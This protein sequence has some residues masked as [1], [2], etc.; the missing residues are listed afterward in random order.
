MRR[1]IAKWLIILICSV[2]SQACKGGNDYS[3]QD[4]VL[5][6]S[7]EYELTLTY[8][9]K[10]EKQLRPRFLVLYSEKDPGL[11]Q[12]RRLQNEFRCAPRWVNYEDDEMSINEYYR[13]PRLVEHTGLETTPEINDEGEKVW[14]FRK[15]GA[16]VKEYKGYFAQGT[17]NPFQPGEQIELE[18]SGYEKIRGGVQYTFDSDSRIKIICSITLPKGDNGPEISYTVKNYIEGYYSVIFTGT[19]RENTEEV[20]RVPSKLRAHNI[21]M[22]EEQSIFPG[23][24][25]QLPDHVSSLIVDKADYPFMPPAATYPM[26]QPGIEDN[27][28][29]AFYI[30]DT[31]EEVQHLTFTPLMGAPSSFWKAGNEYS[32]TLHYLIGQNA[33]DLFQKIAVG[34]YNLRD[35]RDNSGS[36][37]MGSLFNNLRDYL[38]NS[39]GTNF[40]MW[41]EEQKYHDYVSDY[42]GVFKPFS[43]LWAYQTALILDDETLYRERALPIIE[44]SLT[45]PYNVFAPYTVRGDSRMLSYMQKTL[46]SPFLTPN[47]IYTLYLYSGKRSAVLKKLAVETDP[48]KM[49]RNGGYSGLSRFLEEYR[50]NGQ[51]E[52][53]KMANLAGKK[54]IDALIGGV[55]SVSH[56]QPFNKPKGNFM[57]LLELYEETGESDYLEAARISAYLYTLKEIRITPA[58][59]DSKVTVEKDNK[60]P[61]HIHTVGRHLGMGMLYP[62]SFEQAEATVPA[63]RVALTG[64]LSP[65]YM[66]EYWMNPYPQMLRI[67]ALTDDQF[68]RTITRWAMVGRFA[69]FPGDNRG[70][71]SKGNVYSLVAENPEAPL[72]RFHQHTF[73]TLNPGHAWESIGA[74]MD[75]M[76]TDV[77]DRSKGKIDFPSRSMAGSGFRVKSYGFAEGKFFHEKNVRLWMPRDLLTVP[78]KQIEHLSC[79][80]SNSVCIAFYNQSFKSEKC[81]VNLNPGKI[82]FDNEIIADVYVSKKEGEGITTKEV[83]V[84]NGIIEL[85][86]APKGITSYVLK[87]ATAKTTF[88]KK[89]YATDA[90][91]LGEESYLE[92]KCSFGNLHGMLITMGKGLTTAYIYS[93]ALEK[94]VIE[95]TIRYKK[96]GKWI[97]EH[98]NIYPFEFTIEVDDSVETFDFEYSIENYDQEIERSGKMALKL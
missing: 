80:N 23:T 18:P 13:N 42:S 31:P 43:S 4:Y 82:D 27:S 6:I 83:I 56:T 33:V 8:K 5:S 70:G 81:H 14:V 62:R 11:H 24:M 55:D 68:L 32:F 95:A 93:D 41:D 15:E 69:N 40:S 39:S 22:N 63:W 28:R 9:S 79:Y 20:S 1:K 7:G 73:S 74:V 94:D 90:P 53:L 85:E 47:Q 66:A 52:S 59:P 71:D 78:N 2:L 67:A 88:Q 76:I 98:D 57:D 3:N 51:K 12:Q 26:W 60:V 92:K 29:F 21:L 35:M 89:V 84:K 65:A 86:V 87:G 72:R 38:M 91:V 49:I 61:I 77:F 97:A 44:F 16:V 48:E 46:G 37:S 50:M 10:I 25:L 36:G 45:R 96:E 30:K 19:P 75:Y 58:V 64:T 17:V 54:Q 34:Y